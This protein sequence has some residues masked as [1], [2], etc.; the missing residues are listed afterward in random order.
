MGHGLDLGY[1]C[2][3]FKGRL[4]PIEIAGMAAI[5]VEVI[6]QDQSGVFQL[7]KPCGHSAHH[8]APN[9]LRGILPKGFPFIE[10]SAA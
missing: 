3:P 2:F 7:G 4:S 9:E 10:V 6:G 8:S 1:A 5:A